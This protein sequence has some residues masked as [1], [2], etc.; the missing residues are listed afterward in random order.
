MI[1]LVINS[2]LLR[3]I[4]DKSLINKYA[5][6]CYEND[7]SVTE[8]SVIMQNLKTLL[9][10]DKSGIDGMEVYCSRYESIKRK[11]WPILIQFIKDNKE[12]IK[13][14]SLKYIESKKEELRKIIRKDKEYIDEKNRK[15]Y[16]D[17]N[18]TFKG[19]GKKPVPCQYQGRTYSSR[20]E[21]MYKENL[22]K[23]ELYKY[24]KETNQ[25]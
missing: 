17:P 2:V 23:A 16:N 12:K 5:E 6:Y 14:V 15:L 20:Q 22:T 4:D 24:L 9:D 1:Q 18:Y 8:D 21:C 25:V 19:R 13:K 10:W 11:D 3:E 7:I